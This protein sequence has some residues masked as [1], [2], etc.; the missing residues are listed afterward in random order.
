MSARRILYD[1]LEGVEDLA[2]YKPQGFH[3]V[4]LGDSLENGRYRIH[5]KLG[6]GSFSTVWLALDTQIHRYI[7]LKILRGSKAQSDFSLEI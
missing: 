5:N 1:E 4:H 3:V 2:C 6:H 7:A